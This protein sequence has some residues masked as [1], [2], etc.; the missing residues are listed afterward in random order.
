MARDSRRD[1]SAFGVVAPRAVIEHDHAVPGAREVMRGD[2]FVDAGTE[3]KGWSFFF[4]HG[5]GGG[6]SASAPPTLGI[7][8]V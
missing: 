3:D 8:L 2:E 7:L 6:R 5:V 4:G 1:P